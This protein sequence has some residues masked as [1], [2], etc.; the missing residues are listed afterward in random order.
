MIAAE[1]RERQ[2]SNEGGGH[3]CCHVAGRSAPSP[4]VGEGGARSAPGVGSALPIREMRDDIAKYRSVLLEDIIVPIAKNAKSFSTQ[5]QVPL[6]IALR[7]KMMAAVDFNDD[8]SVETNEIQDVI[9]KWDLSAEF[10]THE[11]TVPQKLPH[12]GFSVGRR[13]THGFRET[14]AAFRNQTMLKP[15]RHRPLTRLGPLALATLSHKG[16]G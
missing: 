11:T 15:W 12:G 9:L 8:L 3:G 14:A 2:S 13:P 5:K 4:L 16:R 6:L 7:F 1:I 10:E